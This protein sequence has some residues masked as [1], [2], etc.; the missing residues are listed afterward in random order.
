MDNITISSTIDGVRYSIKQLNEIAFERTQHVLIDLSARGAGLQQNGQ[1]LNL[2]DLD[3]LSQDEANQILLDTKLRLGAAGLK[4][5]YREDLARSDAFWRELNGKFDPEA[6][7]Q[8][9]TSYM[10]VTGL[11]FKTL[12]KKIQES[13]NGDVS[14]LTSNPE[15]FFDEALPGLAP[16]EKCGAET[17]GM[18]GGPVETIVIFDS[19]L[20]GPAKETDGFHN[21]ISGTSKL[22]DG[23]PRHDIAV[24][25]VR[26]H[27]NGFDLKM[28]VYYPQSVPQEMVAGHKR[29]LLI[30]FLGGIV[31]T[32][33]NQQVIDAA[34]N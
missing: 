25:Q 10:S 3:Y 29:H 9:A 30:E 19:K 12:M 7:Y 4:R 18:Y 14:G 26:E 20:T 15:H 31:A 22:L 32:A 17:M 16:N 8:E 6:G 2:A 1:P 34:F 13:V 28:S 33:G 21:V 5:V 27:E 24:H 23:T 11:S